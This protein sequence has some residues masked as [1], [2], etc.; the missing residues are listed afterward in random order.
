MVIYCDM[1]YLK[2][3]FWNSSEATE[4]NRD[5]PKDVRCTQLLPE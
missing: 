5:K 2:I 4:V 3:T 1:T